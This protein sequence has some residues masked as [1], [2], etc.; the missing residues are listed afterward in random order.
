MLRP[1]IHLTKYFT[2]RRKACTLALV[3]AQAPWSVVP[4]GRGPS[5]A[6]DEIEDERIALAL[7]GLAQAL[8]QKRVDE[9]QDCVGRGTCDVC[10]L[11]GVAGEGGR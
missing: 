1:R 7:L 10:V 4:V 11:L 9:D 5:C 3:R 2:A 6:G 8:R